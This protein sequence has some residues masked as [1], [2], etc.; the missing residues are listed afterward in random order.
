MRGM[1]KQML[2]FQRKRLQAQKP[3]ANGHR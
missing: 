2:D 3:S 1:L